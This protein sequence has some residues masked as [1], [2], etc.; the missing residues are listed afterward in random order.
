MESYIT[1]MIRHL[2]ERQLLSNVASVWIE[3]EY[4]HVARLVYINGA[5]RLTKGNDVGL[6]PAAASDVAR[7]KAYAK[8]VLAGVGLEVPRGFSFLMPWWREKIRLPS[9]GI[10]DLCVEVTARAEAERLF[11]CYVKPVDGSKGI[12]I[13]RC[14]A[15]GE[16]S[17]VLE[18]YQE[19]KVRV[20]L[21]EEALGLPDYRLAV[22][23]G[24]LISAYERRPLAV[25]GDG[26]ST[27]TELLHARQEE[28]VRSGRDTRIDKRDPA[29][30]ASLRRVG[31]GLDSVPGAGVQITVRDVSNLSAGGTSRDV[32]DRVAPRW[33]ETAVKAASAFGLRL[34]GVDL[35]CSDI[36]DDEAQYSI[37]EVN[38]SPGL[39]HYASTGIKQERIVEELYARV[40]NAFPGETAITRA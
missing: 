18:G 32:T 36:E 19:D 4:G 2:D 28:F 39:D 20:G 11:P 22:L 5:V 17:V 8:G 15:P 6:N 30:E 24:E 7:D 35:M 10:A 21:L 33:V 34:C 12:G 9:S 26:A 31:M 14:D 23:D 25:T 13:Y 38:A 1:R 3:P 16:L 37:I 27:I 40:L 29:I